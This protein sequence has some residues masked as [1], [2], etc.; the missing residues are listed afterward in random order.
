M[1]L[2]EALRIAWSSMFVNKFRSLLT[3]LG[4]IIGVGSVVGMLA[5]GN[6]L[7]NFFNSQFDKIG[8]GV[9]YITSFINSNKVDDRLAA[10]LTYKDAEAIMQLDSIAIVAVEYNGNSAISTGE[11]HVYSELKGVTP[12]YFSLGNNDLAAGRYLSTEEEQNQSRVAVLDFQVAKN[13][14]DEP[15]T[16]IGESFTVN[17]SKFEVIGVLKS[18]VSAHPGTRGSVYIPYQTARNRIFRN[19]A[20]S[21]IDVSTIQVKVLDRQKINSA[22]TEVTNLLRER[23]RLTYQNND[24]SI[25]NLDQI[26]DSMNGII[27]GFNAFLGSIA[28]ISLLVGGIGIMNIMLVSVT[29]RTREIGLR[30]AVGAKKSDILL[31]FLVESLVLSLMGGILG[32]GLGYALSSGGTFVLTTIFQ[33]TGAEASVSVSSIILATVVSASIGIFFGI[34]PAFQAAN[35]NPIEALRSE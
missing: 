21:K 5:I 6:G 22:I 4:I 14:F 8:V 19:K 12:P 29:E 35:L 13:L 2:F 17:G 28:A 30:K 16:A 23:H 20:T 10:Q 33:A 7:S 31:Q 24:F 26:L 34:F 3:M 1:N 18:V 9:F 15:T 11:K 25:I 27:N 32:V